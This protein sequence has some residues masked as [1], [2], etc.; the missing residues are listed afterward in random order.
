MLDTG[1]VA[2][3]LEGIEGTLEELI[4]RVDAGDLRGRPA[5]LHD[6]TAAV[7][8]SFEETASRGPNGE[9]ADSDGALQMRQEC[10]EC[11]Q[12]AGAQPSPGARR[13]DIHSERR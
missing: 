6:E 3:V 10:V 11:M 7:R 12:L 13:V 2:A 9:L 1:F 8:R 4:G 5:A